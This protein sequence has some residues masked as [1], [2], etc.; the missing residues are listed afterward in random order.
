LKKNCSTYRFKPEKPLDIIIKR[1]LHRL[2][3]YFEH[4]S[5]AV[6]LPKVVV[7]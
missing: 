3:E 4:I 1:K 5:C 6:G 7:C 2:M